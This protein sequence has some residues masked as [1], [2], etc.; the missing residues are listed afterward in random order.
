MRNSMFTNRNIYVLTVRTR[1]VPLSVAN[2]LG[3]PRIGASVLGF[4]LCL[5]IGDR[6]VC[7]IDGANPD[8]RALNTE[9]QMIAVIQNKPANRF[10]I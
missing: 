3:L 8:K 5:I 1:Q 2:K 9:A 7:E 4:I 10:S 6:V